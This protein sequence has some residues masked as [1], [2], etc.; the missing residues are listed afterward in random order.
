MHYSTRSSNTPRTLLA[1]LQSAPLWTDAL[2]LL[3]GSPGGR[4]A[5]TTL[6]RYL[7]HASKDLR[8]SDFR[9]I[10]EQTAPVAESVTMTIPE[11]LHAE[12]L[13]RGKAE[14]VVVLLRARGLHVPAA[15]QARIEACFEPDTLERWL[16]RAATVDCV[17]DVFAD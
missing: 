17:D 1:L 9:A 10:L 5:L 11:Q 8:F 13:A 3:A 15:T 7:F 4:D 14:S 6:L 2:E 16:V 12:G